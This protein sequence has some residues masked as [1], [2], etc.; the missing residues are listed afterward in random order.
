M[1]I[2]R[3]ALLGAGAALPL[4]PALPAAAHHD[5]ER[6]HAQAPGFY[7]FTLGRFTITVVSDGQ[8]VRADPI[9]GFVVNVPPEQVEQAFRQAHLPLKNLVSPFAPTVVETG[10]ETILFDTGTGGQL[11]PSAGFLPRNLEASGYTLADIDRVVITHFH[12]DHI[13]GLTTKEGTAVFAKAP[14]LVPEAEWAWWMDQ[15]NV[16]RTPEAQRGNFANAGRRFAPYAGRVQKLKDGEEIA[17][18]LRAVAAYG[19]TPGHMAYHLADGKDQLFIMGDCA[20]RPE[21]FLAHP[22]WHFV[23]DVDGPMAAET[24]RRLFGR[25]ADEGAR[26]IGHHFPFPSN[27]T[28]VREGDAFRYVPADWSSAV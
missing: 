13:S 21:I 15:G 17:P 20:N 26:V 8:G 6:A 12:G 19:H 4:L 2:A 16:T 23:F 27:G 10:T 25:A 14:I 22:D 28:V 11:V 9:R 5:N 3:R 24:R 1:P 18:G 7:R